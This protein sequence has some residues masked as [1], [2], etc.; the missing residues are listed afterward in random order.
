MSVQHLA[1]VLGLAA[2][3][4][5]SSAL[6]A[7]ITARQRQLDRYSV[8]IAVTS[9]E[10]GDLKPTSSLA[11]KTSRQGP[12]I[13]QEFAGFA[14]LIRPE[15]R[16]VVDRAARTIHINAKALAAA[17]TEPLDPAAMLARVRE[18]GY[19]VEAVD[20]PDRVALRFTSA[21][22]PS[23]ILTFDRPDFML[24]RMEVDG[25]T[26]PAGMAARTVVDYAW[27]APAAVAGEAFDPAH[28]VRQT[29]S[30]WVAAP[31]FEGYRIVVARDR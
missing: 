6:I 8:D 16:L 20:A 17:A 19:E 7:A 5:P 31:A 2:P 13:I 25:G 24:R 14:T 9:F 18:A 28:Y 12:A 10:H 21:S 4:D 15:I 30:H 29:G 3:A 1:L 26:G 23:V 22:R 27:G 11:A